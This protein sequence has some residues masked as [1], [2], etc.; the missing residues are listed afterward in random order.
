MK[1]ADECENIGEIRKEIDR[2]DRSIISRIAERAEYVAAAAKYKKSGD[3]VKAADRVKT[4]IAARR[5]WA[6]ARGCAPDF[7]EDLFRGIVSF[8]V[9]EEM[10]KWK[11]EKIE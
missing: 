8:F 4:M 2:I 10:K 7:I 9:A 11:K 3:E 6:A 1:R 5:E